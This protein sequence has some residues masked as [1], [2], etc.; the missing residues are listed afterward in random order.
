MECK[1]KNCP[2]HGTLSTRGQVLEGIVVSDKM[3]STVIVKRERFIKVRK[4]N[5][6]RKSTSKIP[7][8]NPICINAKAGDSVRLREC[9]KLS[10]TKNFVVIEILTKKQ[11]DK[12]HE[13]VKIVKK[14][15]K[16]KKKPVKKAKEVDNG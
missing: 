13:E 14:S 4:Y 6:Y 1:D 11:E 12:P 7:A 2:I 8:H 10:K 15:A 5:R 3:Q 9:R 16:E